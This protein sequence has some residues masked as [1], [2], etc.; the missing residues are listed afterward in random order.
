MRAQICI[1]GLICWPLGYC[2]ALAQPAGNAAPPAAAANAVAKA[3]VSPPL[4]KSRIAYFRE[5]LAMGPADLDKALAQMPQALRNNLLA[6]LREYTA[7][8]LEQRES[9]LRA[10]E[11]RWYL[12]PLMDLAPTNR[13]AQVAFVPDEYRTLVEQR[14]RLW[15]ELPRQAQREVLDNESAIRYFWQL[16]NASSAGREDALRGLPPEPRRKLEAEL[17]AWQ[18]LPPGRRQRMCDN[19]R[20]YFELSSEERKRTLDTLS[21]AERR[22][23]EKTLQA[24]QKLPAAQRRACINSFQKFANMTPGERQQFLKNAERWKEMSAADRRTWRVL[25]TQLPPLPPGFG[26][27]PIPRLPLPKPGPT[28]QGTPQLT[29]AAP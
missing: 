27:P 18:S 16:Q 2:V 22:E 19:F 12:R 14:L 28:P 20:Q 13:V 4:P 15:D 26:E 7:L 17:A 9:R 23:M 10:T 1:A 29:N 8:P 25:V 11:L 6:K 5:L 24:F 21:E 3:P